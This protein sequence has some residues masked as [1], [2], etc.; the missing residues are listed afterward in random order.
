MEREARLNGVD[1]YEAGATRAFGPGHGGEAR[2]PRPT[3][4]AAFELLDLGLDRR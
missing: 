2:Y 4:A 1:V 3:A